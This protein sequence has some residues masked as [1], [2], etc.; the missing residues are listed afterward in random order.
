MEEMLGNLKEG[1]VESVV[2]L[3]AGSGGLNFG[4]KDREDEGE[5]KMKKLNVR[6]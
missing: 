4:N 6:K 2:R 5:E 1:G 3:A